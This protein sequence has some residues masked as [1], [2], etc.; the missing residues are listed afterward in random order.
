MVSEAR[1]KQML[2]NYRMQAFKVRTPSGHPFK[3]VDKKGTE[4]YKQR[5]KLSNRAHRVRKSEDALSGGHKK[6]RKRSGS[7]DRKKP[8]QR[9]GSGAVAKKRGSPSVA[10]K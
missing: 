10:R 8:R 3:P 6:A 4:A 5:M 7:P 1:Q 2:N 9:S